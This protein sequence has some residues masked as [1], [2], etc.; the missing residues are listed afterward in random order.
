MQLAGRGAPRQSR[1]GGSRTAPTR[2][3]LESGSVGAVREPPVL[4][5]DYRF[6]RRLATG[7]PPVKAAN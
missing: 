3:G 5:R 6:M 1:T 7:F 4:D 2:Y